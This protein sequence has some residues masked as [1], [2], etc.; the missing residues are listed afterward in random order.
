MAYNY[1]FQKFDKE[2]M[3]RACG[4]N[5]QISLKKAVETA[6]AIRGKKLSLVITYLEKVIKQE[7]VVPYKRFNSE[8]PH[9][10]GKGI[11]AGGYPVNV[12]K[13]LLK[14]LK[15]AEKN[16]REQEI[17]G[18]L[19]VI[20]VSCRKG[21]ARYHYGRYSGRKIKSTNV[22][23]IVGTIGKGGKKK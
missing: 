18:D 13:E 19:Y 3:A 22:E 8:M 17:N 1:S 5:L 9:K 12:A 14:L 2:S 7:A 6:N 23:V 21:S 20:S 4:V 10:K 16:A 11:A 15:S